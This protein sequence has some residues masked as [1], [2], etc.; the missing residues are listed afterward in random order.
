MTKKY[1]ICEFCKKHYAWEEGRGKR[2]CSR[3]CWKNANKEFQKYFPE[4]FIKRKEFMKKLGNSLKGKSKSEGHKRNIGKAR[5]KSFKEGKWKPFTFGKKGI[6]LSSKTEFKK[7]H[8]PWNKDKPYYQIRGEK[9]FNWVGGSSRDRGLGWEYLS[10]Q[11]IKRDDYTCQ[12]CG[13]TNCV[14]HTHHIIPY[15]ISK[16]NSS[17]NLITLCDSCHTKIENKIRR[18]LKENIEWKIKKQAIL[19]QVHCH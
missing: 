11:I 15:R 4:T 13:K 14:L 10:R 12:L 1:N 6:H 8:K 19:Q 17:T 16:D 3:D 7:N 9:N 18:I 5:K 2:F